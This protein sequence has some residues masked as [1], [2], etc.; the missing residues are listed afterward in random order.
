MKKVHESMAIGKA[1]VS[2]LIMVLQ[3]V[4]DTQ[5]ASFTTQNRRLAQLAP[6]HREIVNRK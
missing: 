6:M 1:D 5:A 3:A 4:T 2:A